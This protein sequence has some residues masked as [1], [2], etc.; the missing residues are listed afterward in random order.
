MAAPYRL[1]LPLLACVTTVYIA[2]VYEWQAGAS[3]SYYAGPGGQVALRRSGYASGNGLFTLLRDHL[4]SSS[5][6]VDEA[7][8]VVE[9]AY[10][11]SFG[12]NRGD[13]FTDLT[14]RRFTGQYHERGLPGGE[15]LSY[16][17]ARWYDP[18]LGRFVS[19]DTIIPDPTY[20]QTFNRYAYVLNNPLKLIDPSGHIAESFD[21]MLEDPGAPAVSNVAATAA[22]VRAARDSRS[23]PSPAPAPAPRV[24]MGPQP[25]PA[26]TGTPAWGAPVQ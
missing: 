8:V 17:G 25:R 5:V 4:N 22:R 9:R 23:R 10:Y 19:A 1:Y 12:G 13:P 6:L 11:L 14:T 20:P 26:V 18:Q 21:R 3:T 16:Y 24:A 2:G 15:G 7:G